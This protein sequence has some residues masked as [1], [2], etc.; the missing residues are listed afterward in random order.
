MVRRGNQV[1]RIVAAVLVLALTCIPNHAM[2]VDSPSEQPAPETNGAPT[3]DVE[4]PSLSGGMSVSAQ[5]ATAGE[6]VTFTLRAEDDSRIDSSWIALRNAETGQRRTAYIAYSDGAY[7]DGVLEFELAVTDGTSPGRWEAAEVY[8]ADAEGNWITYYDQRYTDEWTP[9]DARVDLSAL[10]FEVYGTTGDVEPPVLVG[11]IGVNV[12]KATVGDD[13]VIALRTEGHDVAA[14]SVV[15]RTPESG[16][17][18]AIPLVEDSQEGIMTGT[19]AVTEET[20]VGIWEPLSIEVT[21]SQGSSRS[22]TNS[23]LSDADMRIAARF[24]RRADDVLAGDSADLSALSFEVVLPEDMPGTDEP[25]GPAVPGDPQD[26]AEPT[27]PHDP[28]TSGMTTEQCGSD[29]DEA[30]PKTSDPSV[31]VAPLVVAG[32]CAVCA[33]CWM[34]T[35]DRRESSSRSR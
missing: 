30:L 9:T 4:A 29:S 13:V 18:F 15:Y 23:A 32:A 2:A 6:T 16:S 14:A 35:R 8:L 26:P 3:D 1:L 10:D 21:D 20:E 7:E 19:F 33:S 28:A 24:A 11:A 25:S 31:S 34:R 22:I 17:T 5:R 27:N 12:K